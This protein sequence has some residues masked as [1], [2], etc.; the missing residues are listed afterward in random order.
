[1]PELN[2]PSDDLPPA[3]ITAA[4]EGLRREL[5]AAL[6]RCLYE[7]CDGV[8]QSLLMT[9]EWY[10]TTSAPALTLVINCPNSSV[11]WRVLNNLVPLATQLAWF[12]EAARI[13]VCSIE[14]TDDPFELRVDEIAIYGD[15]LG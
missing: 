14:E 11:N 2:L 7:L 1:M 6:A 8:T 3:V 15:S 12:S 5:K 10:V 4:D 9:C 13:R